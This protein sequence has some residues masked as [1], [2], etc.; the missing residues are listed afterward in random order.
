MSVYVLVI[1]I[2]IYHLLQCIT[3]FNQHLCWGCILHLKGNERCFWV[4]VMPAFTVFN[5]CLQTKKCNFMHWESLYVR[6]SDRTPTP[7]DLQTRSEPKNRWS[8]VIRTHENHPDKTDV[9]LDVLSVRS[10][11]E[12]KNCL[13]CELWCLP[14]VTI[15]IL[16]IFTNRIHIIINVIRLE[17]GIN[18]LKI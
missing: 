3:I 16:H 9:A 8:S 10:V 18:K 12:L 4:S 6:N 5:C 17:T 11:S 14:F 13:R 2:R 1:R 7:T 15:C